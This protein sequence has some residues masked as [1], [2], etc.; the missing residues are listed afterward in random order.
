MGGKA[1]AGADIGAG[2]GLIVVKMKKMFVLPV[3]G[4]HSGFVDR[5]QPGN[6][7]A[8]ITLESGR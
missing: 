7:R 6:S 2:S 3:G 1:C 8:T 5:H 4:R